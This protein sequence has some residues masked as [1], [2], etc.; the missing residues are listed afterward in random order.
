LQTFGNPLRKFTGGE[1][2]PRKVVHPT[3]LAMGIELDHLVH[4]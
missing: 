1:H 4:A 2:A 3:A